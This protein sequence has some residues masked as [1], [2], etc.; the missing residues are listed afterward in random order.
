MGL[1]RRTAEL[2]SANLH[3]FVERFEQP[4]RMFPPFA[5]TWRCSSKGPL[6]RWPCSIA[7]ERLLART[8][9]TEQDEIARWAQHATAA[10]AAG[11]D[12]LARRA[13]DSG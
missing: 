12:A 2:V 7:A 11:D 10:V 8:Q 13:I 3:D 4:E 9:Q 5:A 6:P 1:F